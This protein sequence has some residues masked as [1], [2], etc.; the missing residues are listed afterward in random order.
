M[1]ISS[2]MV[3]YIQEQDGE[4]WVWTDLASNEMSCPDPGDM[5]FDTEGKAWIWARGLQYGTQSNIHKLSP[6][7]SVDKPIGAN[8]WVARCPRCKDYFV[9]SIRK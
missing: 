3:I 9:M 6:F 7:E 8:D 5:Q 1:E 2:D 4:H